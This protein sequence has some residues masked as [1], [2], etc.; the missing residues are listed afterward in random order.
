MTTATLMKNNLYRF[1]KIHR[2]AY[3]AQLYINR[4]FCVVNPEF[5]VNPRDMHELYIAGGIDIDVIY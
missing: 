1:R 5:I 2:M 4:L 3:P